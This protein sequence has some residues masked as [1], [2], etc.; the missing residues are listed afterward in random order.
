M[1]VPLPLTPPVST[2]PCPCTH[3]CLQDVASRLQHEADLEYQ[4]KA[5]QTFRTIVNQLRETLR[6]RDILRAACSGLISTVDT[7]DV[8]AIL[9]KTMRPATE[10]GG[11]PKADGQSSSLPEAS[12]G[13]VASGG[14][15]D[16]SSNAPVYLECRAFA[17]TASSLEGDDGDDGRPCVYM[18][19]PLIPPP[20]RPG[21]GRRSSAASSAASFGGIAAGSGGRRRQRGGGAGMSGSA[22]CTSSRWGDSTCVSTRP[23]SQSYETMG[24]SW[25]ADLPPGPL[26][27]LPLDGS[28][29]DSL[30]HRADAVL[31]PP[32]EG[33]RIKAALLAGVQASMVEHDID[34][35]RT[36]G[37][38]PARIPPVSG[39]AASAATGDTPAAVSSAA[40]NAA[41][42]DAAA[43]GDREVGQES[44]SGSGAWYMLSL[45]MPASVTDSVIKANRRAD[46]LQYADLAAEGG[47]VPEE[48]VILVHMKVGSGKLHG[49]EHPLGSVGE[50]AMSQVQLEQQDREAARLAIQ[51]GWRWMLSVPWEWTVA[52]FRRA[53]HRLFPHGDG[54]EQPA[55]SSHSER[56]SAEAVDAAAVHLGSRRRGGYASV[57]ADSPVSQ[58]SQSREWQMASASGATAGQP[59]SSSRRDTHDSGVPGAVSIEMPTAAPAPPP[60]EHHVH[61]RDASSA[62]SQAQPEDI[63]LLEDVRD[64]ISFALEQAYAIMQ[65]RRTLQVAADLE[66]Q[67]REAGSVFLAMMSHEMRTPIHAIMGKYCAVLA[68]TCC[69]WCIAAGCRALRFTPDSSQAHFTRASTALAVHVLQATYP[70]YW[71][72]PY[73][74]IR[75]T[76]FGHFNTAA[77]TC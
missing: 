59:S 1:T 71:T 46:K 22:S 18:L 26:A 48:G 16:G 25:M 33:E 11:V 8:C 55:D 66:R 13:G 60:D 19:E 14:S 61:W 76:C 57:D 2:F 68:G 23:R 37:P 51:G 35:E 45:P 21:G 9:V 52:H 64:Q 31:L 67:K 77:T 72:P 3:S 54:I 49:E 56:R 42:A 15:S 36:S 27:T 70:C 17:A 32:G 47:A 12:P 53:A 75:W 58:R 4:N 30:A 41:G 62:A 50:F 24:G 34:E 20:S 28:I 74:Q 69:C 39:P 44:A 38:V 63:H 5:G 73:P 6:Q 43:G 7:L 65:E 29:W 10:A 40:D